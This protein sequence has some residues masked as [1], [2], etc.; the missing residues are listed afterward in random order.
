VIRDYH[1]Q[2]GAVPH[3]IEQV[4]VLIFCINNTIF[5]DNEPPHFYTM[6]QGFGSATAYK[7]IRK[8][9]RNDK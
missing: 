4:R 6:H 9:K 8:D 2:P 1:T 7:T 3:T 5:I